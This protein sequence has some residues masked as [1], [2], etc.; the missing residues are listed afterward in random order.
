MTTRVHARSMSV[1]NMS[2]NFTFHQKYIENAVISSIAIT[3][4][5]PGKIIHA[6]KKDMFNLVS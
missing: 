5:I 6:D 3:F 1:K 4:M 2:I